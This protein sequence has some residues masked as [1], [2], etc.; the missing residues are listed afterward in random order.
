MAWTSSS[1]ENSPPENAVPVTK[2]NLLP[3]IR[4]S[5]LR[6]PSSVSFQ[7]RMATAPDPG[8]RKSPTDAPETR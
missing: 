3:G 8:L 6:K 5:S 7:G 2:G 1:P 4:E